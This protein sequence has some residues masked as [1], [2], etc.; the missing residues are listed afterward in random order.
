MNNPPLY[1]DSRHGRFRHRFAFTI[2][3]LLVAMSVLVVILVLLVSMSDQAAKLWRDGGNHAQRRSNGRALLQF[4]AREIAMAAAPA[5]SSYLVSAGGSSAEANLQFLA[6][7]PESSGSATFIPDGLLNPHAIFWQAPIAKN[8]TA[9]D[10]ACVGYF[11]RW[12]TAT[13]GVARGELC[14]YYTDPADGG[15]YRVYTKENGLPANWLANIDTV[16]PGAAGNY[17]G[18]FADNVIAFWVRLLDAKDRPI[19]ANADGDKISGG[20]GFDSTRGYRDADGLI[21]KAPAF[22]AAVEIA[23]VTV[24]PTAASRITTPLHAQSNGPDRFYD[25]IDS[26]IAG[27]PPAVKVGAQLYTTKVYLQTSLP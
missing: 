27:L 24:E 11:L 16:A 25:D 10:I 14:R 17:R 4:I 20:Y 19:T 9:G 21:Y 26:F 18:W 12:N 6:S 5:S 23:L 22:P 7:M 1:P 8:T 13:T 3:E 15:N 2:V